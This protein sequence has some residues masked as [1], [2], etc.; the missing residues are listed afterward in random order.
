[1]AYSELAAVS[2]FSFLR[3]ASHPAE[4]VSQAKALGHQAVGI[5]DHNTL[6][7]IVRAHSAAEEHDVR[8]LVGARLILTDGPDIICYPQD[9]RAYGRLSRLL[10]MGKMRAEKGDCILSM[11]DVIAYSS[12][13]VMIVCP[14]DQ[15]GEELPDKLAYLA[16]NLR[17]RAYFGVRSAY[18]GSNRA[19]IAELVTMGKTAGLPPIAINEALYHAADRRPLQDVI[20]CIREHVP[21]Q[22]AGRL[23]EANAERHLKA[24]EEM[25]RLFKDWPEALANIEAVLEA[26][27]FSLNE[28]GYEYPDEPVPKGKTPQAHLEDLSWK[29]AAWRYPEGVPHNITKAI[30]KELKLIDELNYAPYFLTV[31]DI[32]AW[33][34]EQKILCQGRGSA[35]NSAVCF[36][37]GITSVNPLDT[38]LLFERFLSKER[39][40]PP[41]IDV[42]F[43]HERREEVM[44][45]IYQRYGR[46]RAALTATVICY[47]PRSAIREVCKALGL[48]EDISS[49]LAGTVWGSW[50]KGLVAEHIRKVGLDPANPM[51]RRAILLAQ[52][53]IGFPRHLSQHVGGFV[54]TRD[55]LVET[56][57]I[58]NAAMEDRTFIEWDKDD[59]SA[60]NIMKVDVLALG[61][62]TCIRKAFEMMALHK[63]LKHNLASIPADDT[64]TY[65][66]LCEGDS[67]GVFQVES[68]AQMNM[69]PRLLPRRYY[70]LVIQ[71]AIVR[72]G[73]IQGDMVHPYLRRRKGRETITYPSPASEHGPPDEL[74]KILGRTLGVPLFQEQA[75]QIA[76]DAAKFTADEANGLRKSMATF[77]KNGTISNYE[78]RM[79]SRM[80]ARGYEPGFAK[81]CFDQIKGFGDYGFPESHAA[82]FAHL[83]YASSWIKCHHPEIFCA[84][85]LN[86]QPMGFY[87]P[88]QIVRDAREHGVDV[89]P[90][91]VNYSQWDNILEPGDNGAWAVRLGFRQIDGVSESEISALLSARGSGYA[92]PNEVR[93]RAGLRHQTLEF[94]AAADAFDSMGLSRREALWAVKGQARGRGLP[95][96]EAAEVAEHGEE[97]KVILPTMPMSEHVLQDYQT[98]RLSLKAHPLDF[99]RKAYG[100]MGIRTTRDATSAPNGCKVDVAGVVLVRQR[101]G[102][103]NGVFFITIEDETGIAN[104][105]VWPKIGELYRPIVMGARILLVRGRIQRADNVTHVV[106]DQLFDRTDDL[107]RLT[108]HAQNDPLKNAIARADEVIRPVPERR[109]PGARS[110]GHGHPRNV[111]I[112]PNSRDFH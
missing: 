75:M 100:E 65:D 63:S 11:A 38:Q 37:L 99:L 25:E 22:K 66:M 34:R 86:S 4:L 81:R 101:P 21:I 28:V 40:E 74:K 53:I 56:V 67:L 16:S 7:G 97:G 32:V 61:M 1:M 36:C 107:S 18:Q 72:P 46:H 55:H 78:E 106:A 80:I 89:R 79:V 52:Q 68:R 54:L 92:T 70:D 41:D 96:F 8:L 112:I 48:S 47:R 5:A 84:A 90:V 44:Q 88:A 10:S 94:L 93:Q 73:P 19:K 62:L 110:A 13:Q 103:A 60:L 95:L 23:L 105:V 64:A 102:S 76:M 30:R 109:G 29:G 2:N 43:E 50:G 59:L 17:S 20:T 35:A 77:R 9:R 27:T 58:G 51:I 82:S 12:G 111:R 69:L 33:A 6:A 15:P 39:K 31:N 85:L 14:P 24:P 26:C 45:Y 108:E 91:D 83:V 57:P 71:V 3:G 104:L 98:T 49:A 42:D 87:A